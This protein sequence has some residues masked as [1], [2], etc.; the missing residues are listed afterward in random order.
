MIIEFR[1]QAVD[2]RRRMSSSISHKQVDQVRRDIIKERVNRINILDDR[3][4]SEWDDGIRASEEVEVIVVLRVDWCKLVET[5]D[6]KDGSGVV[7]GGGCHQHASRG[8]D[9]TTIGRN[10]KI[11]N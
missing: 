10:Y 6:D 5:G 2:I 7:F 3:A 4:V 1:Q 11:H 9:Q 8:G